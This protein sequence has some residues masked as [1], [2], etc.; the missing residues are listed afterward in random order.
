MRDK[1]SV[2]RLSLVPPRPPLLREGRTGVLIDV[3]LEVDFDGA[4]RDAGGQV[5]DLVLENFLRIQIFYS[6]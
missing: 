6:V 4:A 3:E 5:H 2:R 1:E